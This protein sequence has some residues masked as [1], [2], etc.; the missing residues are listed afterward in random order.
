MVNVWME[1]E[2][3]KSCE[4]ENGNHLFINCERNLIKF[5][6]IIYDLS[7]HFARFHFA[8]FPFFK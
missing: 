6:I 5:S 3:E 4:R 7:L 2:T 8:R 1:L